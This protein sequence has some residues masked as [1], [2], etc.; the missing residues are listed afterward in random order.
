VSWEEEQM[1]QTK[2]GT[3]AEQLDSET[4]HVQLSRLVTEHAWRADQGRADTIHE[5][6]VDDG[7]LIVGPTPLRGLPAAG[8]PVVKERVNAVALPTVE[9]IRRDSDLFLEGMRTDEFQK[10]TQAAMKRGF[11]TKDAEMDL[12]RLVADLRGKTDL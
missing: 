11:Q 3:T 9:D 10:L 5:L 7:E 1:S 12:G 8:H 4:D 6:Y 2:S